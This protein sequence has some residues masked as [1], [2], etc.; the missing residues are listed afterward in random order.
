M[1]NAE[2]KTLNVNCFEELAEKEGSSL[3]WSSAFYDDCHFY[4]FI[5]ILWECGVQ[6]LVKQ[7][8]VG[9]GVC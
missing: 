3:I 9:M 4:H 5:S 7:M 1:Q 6:T 2:Q 8:V